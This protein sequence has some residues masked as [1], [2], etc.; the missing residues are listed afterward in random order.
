[1]I[2]KIDKWYTFPERLADAA[3]AM[4]E[5]LREWADQY[6]RDHPLRTADQHD[7]DCK[8]QRCWRDRIRAILS[9]IDGE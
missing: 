6:D 3:P 8:C 4:Y 7:P 9:Q 1:M 5:A 2:R